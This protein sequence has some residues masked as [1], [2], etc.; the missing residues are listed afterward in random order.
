MDGV[1]DIEATAPAGL[2]PV[3]L[4]SKDRDEKM[5]LMLQN[6]LEDRF[7]LKIR[8]EAKEMPAYAVVV[9][10][11]GPELEKAKIDEKDCTEAGAPGEPRASS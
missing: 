3:G 5:R 1:Y 7:K 9:A 8:R 6:L 2:I 11:N 4:P 10:K